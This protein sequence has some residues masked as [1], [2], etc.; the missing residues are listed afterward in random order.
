MFEYFLLVI[1]LGIL[2]HFLRY[3]PENMENFV[4]T[5]TLYTNKIEGNVTG[6]VHIKNY[7]DK[8][9]ILENKINAAENKIDSFNSLNEVSKFIQPIEEKY[10][11]QSN[12][13]VGQVCSQQE[14]KIT[15]GTEGRY[16]KYFVTGINID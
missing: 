3:F 12:K 13:A 2:F 15:V 1:I 8:I 5:N 7:N 10:R 9:Q 4:N 16:G 14:N 11:P 6:T